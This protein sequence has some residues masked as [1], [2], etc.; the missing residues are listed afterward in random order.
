MTVTVEFDYSSIILQ[1]L[2]TKIRQNEIIRYRIYRRYFC[3]SRCSCTTWGKVWI[4][5][6][7]D[8]LIFYFYFY[9]LFLNFIQHFLS[10]TEDELSASI[11][12][13]LENLNLTDVEELTEQQTFCLNGCLM[14]TYQLV[15]ITFILS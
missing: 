15:L 8:I 10:K 7:K 6:S 12:K 11:N 14:Q 13:C 3:C 1:N 5:F 4:F 9:F 2:H